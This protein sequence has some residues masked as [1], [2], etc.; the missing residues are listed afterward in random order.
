MHI[1]HFA[2]DFGFWYQGR[3]RVD[4]DHVNSVGAYQ[5]IGDFQGL[6]TGIRLRHQQVVNVD[7]EF[8]G[9]VRVECMFGID[10]GASGTELLRFGDHR[11]GQGGFTGR[12]R[13][14]DK[15]S[16]ARNRQNWFR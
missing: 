8:A 13:A 5:H 12:L 3:H 6:F 11:Q 7:A 9:I 15:A 2:F 1:A 4:D 16:H 10:E 14:V